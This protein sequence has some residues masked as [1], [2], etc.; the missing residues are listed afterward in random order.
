MRH[1][2]PICAV[3]VCALC[4]RAAAQDVIMHNGG[5]DKFLRDGWYII[6][7]TPQPVGPYA[8]KE[9]CDTARLNLGSGPDAPCD[10]VHFMHD[11]IYVTP[12]KPK[13]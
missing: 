11:F 4:A 3:A 2:W 1:L 6:T 12:P 5:S 8:S 10:R 7:N 9:R 13:G